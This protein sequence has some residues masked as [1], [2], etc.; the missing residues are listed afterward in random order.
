M[1]TIVLVG[2]NGAGKGTRLAR[3]LKGREDRY[4]VLAMSSLLEKVKDTDPELWKKID[5]IMKAGDLVPD[6]IILDI[7]TKELGET[8]KTVVF[9]GFPRTVAQAEAMI[10]K[11]VIP[12]AVVEVYVDDDVIIERAKQ[13]IVCS[14]CKRPYTLNDFD[15]PK[16]EGICDECG[17]PLIRRADD[18]EP[19]VRKR[20]KQYKEQTQPII[21]ILADVGVVNF[22][23]VNEGDNDRIQALF[24]EVMSMF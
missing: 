18:D 6:D 13:R 15:P 9:D 2:K 10:A 1:S 7:I 22:K 8:T 23:I 4:Q 19:I 24:D 12:K 3:F 20:L 17:A 14:K 11:G 5:A 16:V 21:N